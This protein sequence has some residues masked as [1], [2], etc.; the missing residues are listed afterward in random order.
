MA[1][2]QDL[3]DKAKSLYELGVPY[4]Q[5]TKATGIPKG[6]ISK[7][8]NKENWQKETEKLAIK[9]DVIAFEKKKET[10][11][12]QKETIIKQ[13]SNL[14]DYQITV[15]DKMIEKEIGHQSMVFNTATLSLIRKN[16]MLERN[17]K[18]IT[19]RSKIADKENGS[20]TEVIE[21]V[22]VPLNANDYKTLD[23]GIDK[24]AITLEVAPRHAPKIEV[25]NTNAQQNNKVIKIEYD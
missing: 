13:V 17:K 20:Y 18:T 10:L 14:N 25:T 2:N 4:E 22:E 7:K 1:I 15:L 5:I 6:T 16:Q 19:L 3:W 24:N 21:L 8:V 12:L 23:E 9:D 11:E